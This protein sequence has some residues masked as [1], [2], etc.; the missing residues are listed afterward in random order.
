MDEHCRVGIPSSDFDV[1]VGG[2]GSFQ[3]LAKLKH[4]VGVAFLKSVSIYLKTAL[5]Y[6]H[7][8]YN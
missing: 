2:A 7:V 3:V 1:A 4:R 5:A 8:T 6:F